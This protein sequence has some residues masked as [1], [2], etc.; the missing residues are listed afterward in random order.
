MT[1]W[2]M[3]TRPPGGAVAVRPPPAAPHWARVCGHKTTIC[4]YNGTSTARLS[5]CTAR[6]RSAALVRFG[7]VAQHASIWGGS[8]TRPAMPMAAYTAYPPYTYK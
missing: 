5:V 6:L 2:T 8:S 7:L 3:E 4:T 1:D